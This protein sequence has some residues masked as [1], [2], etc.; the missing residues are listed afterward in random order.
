MPSV[1]VT[2]KGRCPTPERRNSLVRE[3][4]DF[5]TRSEVPV[6][7][8]MSAQ[9]AD[10]SRPKPTIEMGVR[11]LRG[12]VGLRDDLL[13]DPAEFAEMAARCELE[14]IDE[15]DAGA[16]RIAVV[17]LVELQGIE[18]RLYDPRQLYPEAD[19][20]SFWF[21][22]C[23]AAP[24]LDGCIASYRDKESC[25]SS[26]VETLRGLDGYVECPMIHLRYLHEA[27]LIFL[28]SWIKYFYVPELRWW[29]HE[30]MQ[31]WDVWQPQFADAEHESDKAS[32]ASIFH[33]F[34]LRDFRKEADEWRPRTED[35]AG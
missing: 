10:A 14:L 25:A 33:L 24:Y 9:R 16:N 12:R 32:A 23:P 27:W 22:Q 28:L 31:G 20:L 35:D 2:W 30:E 3:L 4:E 15:E 7:E 5:A 29:A 8:M 6:L 1:I 13:P 19:R 11:S 26:V 17:P 34:L 21:L 18:F